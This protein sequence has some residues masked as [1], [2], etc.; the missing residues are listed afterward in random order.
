MLRQR[1]QYAPLLED[2]AGLSWDSDQDLAEQF[3]RGRLS[4]IY[5]EALEYTAFALAQFRER[6]DRDGAELVIL[7]NHVIKE[8]GA[9]LFDWLRETAA[10]QGIPVI[11]QADYIRRQG[12]EPAEAHWRHNYH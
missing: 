9:G 5:A 8:R 10:A 2:A 12:G 6:A 4:P 1:P 7:T 3:A 11:D